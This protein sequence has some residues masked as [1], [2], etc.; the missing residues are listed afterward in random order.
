V[1]AKK[2]TTPGRRAHL[3]IVRIDPDDRDAR[4]GLHVRVQRW[5]QR[6]IWAG[7]L[8]IATSFP[9]ALLLCLIATGGTVPPAALRF[10]LCLWLAA[11]TA[12]A[13]CAEA[14]WRNRYLLEHTPH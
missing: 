3:A 12:V 13:L 4:T 11:V 10:I 2:L 1:L 9:M 8:L 14:A 5:E 7:R 6:R